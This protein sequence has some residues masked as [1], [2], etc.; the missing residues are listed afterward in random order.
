MELKVHS[1]SEVLFPQQGLEVQRPLLTG[2]QHNDGEVLPHIV[3]QIGY[4]R[5]QARPIGGKLLGQEIEDS[6]GRPG[7]GGGRKCVQITERPVLQNAAQLLKGAGKDRQLAG[8]LAPLHQSLTVFRYLPQPSPGP[9]CRSAALGNQNHRILP[10]V[11]GS[12]GQFRVNQGQISVYCRKGCLGGEPL[13]ILRQRTQQDRLIPPALLCAGNECV[14]GLQQSTIPAGS[15]LGQHLGGG[16]DFGLFQVPCPPLGS[17]VKEA[18]GVYLISKELAAHRPVMCRGEKIQDAA[19]QSKLP[20][21]LH[22]VAAGVASGG[23][24]L[25]QLVQ[26]VIFTHSQCLGRLEQQDLRHRPLKEGFHRGHQEGTL[27]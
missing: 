24:R 13:P 9:L 4:S 2:H 12:R 17:R 21:P 6:P 27:P 8:Q 7:I 25:G 11:V 19:P 26:V 22:L 23:Q 14:Q 15:K 3:R 16:K 20:Y 5:L 10:Q 18:H 1:G